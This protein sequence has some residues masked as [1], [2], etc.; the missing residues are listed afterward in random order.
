MEFNTSI[1]YIMLPFKTMKLISVKPVRNS[2]ATILKR[3]WQKV[4]PL[5][6]STLRTQSDPPKLNMPPTMDA[7]PP[8]VRSHTVPTAP[9][10]FLDNLE[11]NE[12]QTLASNRLN[13]TKKQM[14]ANSLSKPVNDG[15]GK[16]CKF[17]VHPCTCT[18][19]ELSDR[20]PSLQLQT[21]FEE[22]QQIQKAVNIAVRF[23]RAPLLTQ[24]KVES[25]LSTKQFF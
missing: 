11:T 7:F 10:R 6:S 20:Y 2:Y 4:T 18:I 9:P 12:S 16:G 19:E 23:L 3:P 24:Y 14:E 5:P 13:W 21:P 1:T 17:P 22:E 25:V 8:L 15:F